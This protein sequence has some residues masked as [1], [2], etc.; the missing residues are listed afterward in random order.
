VRLTS[1][2]HQ[3]V[4]SQA[5]SLVDDHAR[6][7]IITRTIVGIA[8][9]GEFVPTFARVLDRQFSHAQLQRHDFLALDMSSWVKVMSPPPI[10]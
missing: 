9:Y 5:T 4:K 1:A 6:S 3:R 2:A 7:E 10:M 8:G